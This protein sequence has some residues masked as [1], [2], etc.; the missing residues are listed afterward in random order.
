MTDVQICNLALARLGDARI[1][2]LADATAQAQFCTLFYAQTVQELETDLDWQFCRKLASVNADATAPTFGFAARFAIPA[3]F[4]RALRINGVDASE[5][6]GQW[7][8]LA[9]YIHTN[10]TGPIQLD[11]IASTTTTALFPAIFI[12]LLTAKLAGNLAMPLTGSKDL[13]A[14]MVGIFGDTLKRPAVREAVVAQSS[15]RTAP[16]IS[17][18]E[19]CRQAILRLGLAESF[20][21]SMQAFLLAGTLYPQ[22]RDSL[23]TA[24]A[25]TWA[26]KT[27]TLT[28]DALDPEFKWSHR[29]ALPSDCLRIMRVDELEYNDPATSWEVQGSYLLTDE[30]TD[31][32]E[33]VTGRAYVVG[34]AVTR[35]EVVYRCL[36]AN[37]AGTFA[38]DLAASKWVV[39][40]GSLV[41][42]EY[43]FQQTDATKFDA[44]FVDLITSTL[45]AKLATPVT[46]DINKAAMLAREAEALHKNSSMRR[47]S[48]ER[49]SRIQPAWM[50]SKLV[51]S[52]NA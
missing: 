28:S 42:I 45:A 1:T 43:I 8:I 41:A 51:N 7:E 19:I 34:N 14:Q 25:W 23:L 50:T 13:F 5:N 49:K 24:G 12:E 47:D 16:A 26:S 15:G 22:V 11:Y 9:G 38:T 46:G 40:A 48:T 6:F 37:T 39:W 36:T 2:T 29:Y 35:L 4:L 21:P 18:G 3:D 20:T 52:R 32:P 27:T 33:W 17:A 30:T 31:A 10:L 44:G